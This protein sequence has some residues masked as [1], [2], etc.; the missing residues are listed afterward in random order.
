MLLGTR[1]QLE[2]VGFNELRVMRKLVY[3]VARS[4]V[5]VGAAAILFF[6]IQTDFMSSFASSNVLPDLNRRLSD[7]HSL[8]VQN[9]VEAIVANESANREP[10][11]VPGL[12]EATQRLVHEV[13]YVV[14]VT[15]S[16]A[17][18]TLEGETTQL[19]SLLYPDDIEMREAAG[20][21]LNSNLIHLVRRELALDPRSL[22]LLI[23]WS[24]LAGFS[25]KLVP[26]MLSKTEEKMRP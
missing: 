10:N 12:E 15:K 17:D 26:N 1:K 20:Q 21:R 2:N 4:M 24:F 8:V 16:E 23:V 6:F 14:E 25:E 5:G 18:R 3:Q 13:K 9:A 7:E 11:K 22:A 19:L